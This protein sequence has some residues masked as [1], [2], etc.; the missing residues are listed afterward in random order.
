MRN[1]SFEQKQST[2]MDKF[3]AKLRY[4]YILNNLN[5]NYINLNSK[6]ICDV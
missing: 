1:F 4:S 3:I 5:K 6:N 2:F